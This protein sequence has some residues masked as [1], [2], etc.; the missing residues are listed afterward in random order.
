MMKNYNSLDSGRFGRFKKN[1]VSAVGSPP[2][3]HNTVGR[4]SWLLFL[5]MLLSMAIGQKTFS[6]SI[7]NYAYSTG[8]TGSLEDLSTGATAIMTGRNDDTGGT[9]TAIGF[10]FTFMVL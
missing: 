1:G 5:F 3:S 6:Q 7:S 8:T 4:K 10:N 2:S 9:V